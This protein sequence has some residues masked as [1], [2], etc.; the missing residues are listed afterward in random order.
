MKVYDEVSWHF[1]D[2]GAESLE[3]AKSH[4]KVLMDW[5]YQNQLLSPD[6]IEAYQVGIDSDFS[7]TDA[8]LTTEGNAIVNNIYDKWIKTIDY[9]QRPKLDLFEIE[10]NYNRG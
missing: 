2:G 1:P 8:M 4:F 10:L 9:K 7:I 3:M 6:G 5:L